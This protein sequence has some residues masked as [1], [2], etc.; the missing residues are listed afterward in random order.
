[1]GLDA[2]YLRLGLQ[3]NHLDGK[4]RSKE[5][6]LFLRSYFLIPVWVDFRC[7]RRLLP[8]IRKLLT[9]TCLTMSGVG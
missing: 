4:T 6:R 9:T 5:W 7:L 8:L 2:E 1:M 3:A